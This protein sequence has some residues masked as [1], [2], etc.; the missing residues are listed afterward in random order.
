TLAPLI[1]FGQ[2]QGRMRVIGWLHDGDAADLLNAQYESAF[3]AGMRDLGYVEGRDYRIETRFAAHNL[4]ELPA[5][6][7]QLVALK[8]DIIIAL[9]SSE[10]VAAHKVTHQVPIVSDAG[11]PVGNGLAASLSHPGGNVTGMT[12]NSSELYVKRVDLLRQ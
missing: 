7:A 2:A 8:V 5:L 1:C 3:N 10:A 4:S 11:D 6:A 12:S 9:T